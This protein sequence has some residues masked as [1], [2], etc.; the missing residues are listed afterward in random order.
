MTSVD[1]Q[2]YYSLGTEIL[3]DGMKVL[4]DILDEDYYANDTMRN[5]F[6]GKIFTIERYVGTLYEENLHYYVF[7]EDEEK[8][9]FTQ[10]MLKRTAQINQVLNKLPDF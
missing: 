3:P 9:Y 7:V 5:L 4:V 6:N 2:E 1:S 8:F 10:K